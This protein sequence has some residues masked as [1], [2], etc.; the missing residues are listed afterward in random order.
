VDYRGQNDRRQHELPPTRLRR[1]T[2]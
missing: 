1:Y 2:R